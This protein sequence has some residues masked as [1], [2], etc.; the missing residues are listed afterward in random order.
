[1]GV[2]DGSWY[3]DRATDVEIQMAQLVAEELHIRKSLSNRIVQNCVFARECHTSP[4]TLRDQIELNWVLAGC[5]E[6]IVAVKH[7]ARHSILVAVLLIFS[8]S[9]YLHVRF[10][11][12]DDVQKLSLWDR[13]GLELFHL[14][15]DPVLFPLSQMLYL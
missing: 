5:F 2:Q 6:A 3:F 8:L 15:P 7:R 11:I 9:I 10:L 14:L 1:M 12:D 4:L 13:V